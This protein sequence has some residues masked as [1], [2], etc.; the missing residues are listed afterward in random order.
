MCDPKNQTSKTKKSET[1]S[2]SVL[3]VAT[4]VIALGA[5]F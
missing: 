5:E 1:I 2:W 3:Q 4:D